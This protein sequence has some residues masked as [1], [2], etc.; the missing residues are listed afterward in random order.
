MRDMLPQYPTSEV[1]NTLN[2]HSS[3][4]K[5]VLSLLKT[6][7]LEIKYSQKISLNGLLGAVQ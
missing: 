5:V 6:S 7:D 4:G 3:S 1:V 2:S